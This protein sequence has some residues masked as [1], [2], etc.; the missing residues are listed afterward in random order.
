MATQIEHVAYM[1]S[2]AEYPE[3]SEPAKEWI[4]TNNT[5]LSAPSSDRLERERE[6]D[7]A[8]GQKI[9]YAL[10]KKILNIRRNSVEDVEDFRIRNYA[11]WLLR[12]TSNGGKEPDPPEKPDVPEDDI[13][14]LTSLILFC[15][16]PI[17]LIAL[18]RYLGKI[19]DDTFISRVKATMDLLDTEDLLYQNTL[20]IE[21]A[22][23]EAQRRIEPPLPPKHLPELKHY[24]VQ[25][26]E[27]ILEQAKRNMSRPLAVSTFLHVS[28]ILLAAILFLLV[29]GYCA[30]SPSAYC[31]I[32]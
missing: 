7:G 20:D 24:R 2:L 32:S 11:L 31:I 21:R 15:P 19:D 23:K 12:L 28:A 6:N 27:D 10:D 4:K 5:I 16:K 26:N 14:A 22:L 3:F 25:S 13:A 9:A 8:F 1:L 17:A 18:R 30:D 29:L